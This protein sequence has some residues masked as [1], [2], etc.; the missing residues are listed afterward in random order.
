MGTAPVYPGSGRLRRLL[1]G[2]VRALL[3]RR[4]LTIHR[5]RSAIPDV[6]ERKLMRLAVPTVAGHLG[7]AVGGSWADDVDS[8]R[9]SSVAARRRHP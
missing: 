9:R 4:L 6:G 3:V 8:A 7:T 2:M 5:R 1:L